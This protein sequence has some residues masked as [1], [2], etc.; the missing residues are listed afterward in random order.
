MN[1]N[2]KIKYYRN[3]LNLTQ[4]ELADSAGISLRALS[5]YE[6]GSRVPSMEVLI[7][8]A[9]A[10]DVPV[11]EIQP[12]LIKSPEIEYLFAGVGKLELEQEELEDQRGNDFRRVA[13]LFEDF[14]YQ[15]NEINDNNINKVEI[16]TFEDG[17]IMTLD[18]ND[19]I[20]LGNQLINEI[21]DSIKLQIKQFIRRNK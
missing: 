7:K 19:F 5:N 11:K 15:I 18:E 20:N 13:D 4:Q 6:R 3:K 21:D 10:L 14:D 12:K 9:K 16:S 2:E 8:I 17:T 1:L